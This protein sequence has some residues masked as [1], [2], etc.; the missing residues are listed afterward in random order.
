[1]FL[2]LQD[3]KFYTYL[4]KLKSSKD[5]VNSEGNVDGEGSWG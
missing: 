2:V 3:L 4:H 5:Y 1:M